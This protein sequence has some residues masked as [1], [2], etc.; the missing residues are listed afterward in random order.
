MKHMFLALSV[1][2]ST[3]ALAQSSNPYADGNAAAQGKSFIS[4]YGTMQTQ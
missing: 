3:L 4:I 1:F 2:A